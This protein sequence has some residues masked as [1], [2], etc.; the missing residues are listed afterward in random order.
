M[1][2][3]KILWVGS[4]VACLALLVYAWSSGLGE[5]LIW[6]GAFLACIALPGWVMFLDDD[7]AEM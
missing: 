1:A 2:Y 5:E 3:K 4:F 7:N 6:M